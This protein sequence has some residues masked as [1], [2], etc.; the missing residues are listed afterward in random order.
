MTFPMIVTIT[1]TEDLQTH[2]HTN[3]DVYRQKVKHPSIHSNIIYIYI[4]RERERGRE[5]FTYTH[6]YIY[7]NYI[8]TA[9]IYA[10]KHMNICIYIY[11]YIYIYISPHVSTYIDMN[12]YQ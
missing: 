2:I 5:R 1:H 8:K 7:T 6:A 10:Q 4:Y 9:D 12:M 11:I 3:I